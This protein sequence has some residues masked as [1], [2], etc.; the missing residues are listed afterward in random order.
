MSPNAYTQPRRTRLP[1]TR[2][3]V[4]HRISHTGDLDVYI[5][6]G[7]YTPDKDSVEQ[8]GEIFVKLGKEGS[9]LGGLVDGLAVSWSLALQYGIP[10]E[11][12]SRKL[13]DTKFEPLNHEGK[14]V[15]HAIVVAVDRILSERG[16]NP[17][18]GCNGFEE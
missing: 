12:L 9:T 18:K 13:R 17:T 5:T 11:R 8:P 4:T 14:S 16:S 6:V 15:L 7:F 2:A 3:S 10:W 1:D